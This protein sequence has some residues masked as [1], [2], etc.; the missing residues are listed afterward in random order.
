MGR[1]IIELV[2]RANSAELLPSLVH[3]Y[4]EPFADS[5]AI[6]TYH[7]AQM[8]RR[9]VTVALSGDGGDES[10]GGYD[11]YGAVARWGAIDWVPRTLRRSLAAAP[12]ALLA[13]LPH[14]ARRDRLSRGLTMM[15]GDLAERYRL[16]MT[17]LKPEEKRWLYA[18]GFWDRL[19]GGHGDAVRALDWDGEMD[20]TEWMML[21][22][23]NFYLP[24]CLLVK[25]D[26]ASMANSLEVRCPL[27]DYTLVE[28]AASLPPSLKRDASGGKVLLRQVA[29]TFLPEAVVNKPKTGFGI[30]VARWLR[31]DMAELVR[32]VLLD[33]RAAARG[34]FAPA[35]VREMVQQ[36]QRG[37]RDWS[38][39]LWALVC[40]ELWFREFIDQP[41]RRSIDP[42][43][44]PAMVAQ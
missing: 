18:P 31:E 5:S 43:P 23:R 22:D 21:H 2:V 24:D 1:I 20:A 3:F 12:L 8:A 44:H 14:S 11:R 34:L 6:P 4:G 28:W 25:V 35:S 16:H 10:F 26:I 39:R 37:E 29:R 19:R 33:D 41:S 9:N 38:N 15:R 40:L 13:G 17:T 42:A 32:S 30:P 7:V 27:L 36:H